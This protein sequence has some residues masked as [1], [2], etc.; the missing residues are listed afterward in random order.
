MSKIN[1]E[2][3]KIEADILS[4]N[5]NKLKFIKEIKDGLGSQILKEKNKVT[6][7]KVS[8]FTR[9]INRLKKIF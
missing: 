5:I 3:K 7:I 6:I 8:L 4:T 2:K 9:I 1:A